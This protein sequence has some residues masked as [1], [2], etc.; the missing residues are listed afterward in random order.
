VL[1]HIENDSPDVVLLDIQMPGM[2]GLECAEQLSQLNPRPAIIFCTAYEYLIKRHQVSRF[3]Y[4]L[5][6][7]DHDAPSQ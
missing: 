3:Q 6:H 4:D 2:N 5:T 1:N 7:P